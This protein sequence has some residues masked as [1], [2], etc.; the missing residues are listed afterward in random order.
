MELHESRGCF[1]ISKSIVA[2]RFPT[3]PALD[4]LRLRLQRAADAGLWGDP[5]VERLA[6]PVG[7]VFIFPKWAIVT[8]W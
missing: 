1:R 4:G 2:A 3:G 6:K 7:A 5:V 8:L